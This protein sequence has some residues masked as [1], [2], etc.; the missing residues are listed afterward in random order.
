MN[1]T[2]TRV[3]RDN[4]FQTILAAVNK[5]GDTVRPTFGPASNKVIIDKQIYRMVVDDGVQ[6]ARD[7]ELPD[8][9]EN[10]VIKVI[11]ETA[12]K[13]NDRGGDGTTGALIMVQS[14]LQ[15]LGQ[16]GRIDG[17]KVEEEL[18]RGFEEF[19]KQMTAAARPIKTKEE[20]KKVALISF[21]N[22]EIA[23]MISNLY[24]KLGKDAV[25]TIDK[26][27]TLET[28]VETTE[29]TKI[30][31]GYIS[32]YMI[33]DGNRMETV[34]EKPY[35]L[36]TDYRITEVNDILPIMEKMVKEKKHELIVICEN[37]E[38]GALA[39]A[40]VNRMQGKF[41][42]VA[43]P[44][45][46]DDRK[47]K[48]EDLALLT[49]GR[50]FSAEKGDKLET[51]EIAD[52]GRSERII[53]R[54]DETIIVTPKGKKADI[55][56]AITALR[57]NIESEKDEKTREQYKNRLAFYTNT[58]AVIKVGAVTENEQ[59]ALKY[60]V[61]DAVNAV[62]SAYQHGVVPGSG[63]MLASI[64]TSS[65]ILNEALKAPMRQLFENM[66]MDVP[67]LA[68]GHA[69]NVVTMEEG[70]FMEVGVADPADVLI[71]GVES[72]VS[73]ASLLATSSRMIVE[74][75]KEPKE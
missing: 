49:G 31:R 28:I 54:R 16:R 29:G 71:A 63:I 59:K 44:A 9:F 56:T 48:L 43:I 39:T 62:K 13:T 40:I 21:N 1:S 45:P 57:S 8:P 55:A 4:V 20:L 5:L 17:R 41:L 33:V 42:L 64:E 36:L 11:R 2:E 66:N 67:K 65:S 68:K 10:A 3:L 61:E 52:L 12:V 74:T 18:K 72:A 26:S 14:I 34:L 23:E 37:M 47:Q 75:P 15:I 24:H 30:D 53:V 27:P 38:Q 32:P 35:I 22:E 6:I 50:F 60:K 69:L 58:M 19:K 7:F 46:S 51:A 70:A 73:I 25:I